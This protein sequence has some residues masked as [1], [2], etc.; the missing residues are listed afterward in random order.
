MADGRQPSRRM[1]SAVS[2]VPCPSHSWPTDDGTHERVAE[3]RHAQAVSRQS[4]VESRVF[5]VSDTRHTADGI[6][7]IGIDRDVLF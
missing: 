3:N 2:H 7:T 1:M 6:Y 5:C 4:R